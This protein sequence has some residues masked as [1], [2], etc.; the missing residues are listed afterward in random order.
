MLKNLLAELRWGPLTP[1]QQKEL[2]TLPLKE[3][4]RRPYLAPKLHKHY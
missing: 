3:V 4:F 1:E 2:D